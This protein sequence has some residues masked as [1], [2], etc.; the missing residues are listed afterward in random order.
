MRRSLVLAA[1]LLAAPAAAQTFP[2]LDPA[3]ALRLQNEQR[4]LDTRQRALEA[5]LGRLGTAQTLDRL[6]RQ[7]LPDAALL[8]RQAAQDAAEADALL[9]AQQARSTLR[10]ARLRSALA[11]Q[12]YADALPLPRPSAEPPR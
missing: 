8:R 9:R 6:S 1:T 7:G 12:G 10:A 4:Y 2:A 5:E 11:A 3:A